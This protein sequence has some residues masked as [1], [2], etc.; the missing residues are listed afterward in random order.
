M[1]DREL[2]ELAAKAALGKTA[3]PRHAEDLASRWNPLDEDEAALRLAVR[4]RMHVLLETSE[5]TVAVD[6]AAG[7]RQLVRVQ[8]IAED[9]GE[10]I[11]TRRAIVRA[12]AEIG[13]AM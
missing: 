5:V 4:L 12:A 1:D 6:D 2:L 3:I 11:A 9:Q 8:F 13:R 7:R 10:F